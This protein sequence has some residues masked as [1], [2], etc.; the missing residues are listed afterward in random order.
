MHNYRRQ[1][2]FEQSHALLIWV[3]KKVESR[4]AVTR[5][6]QFRPTDS[7]GGNS[8]PHLINWLRT[9]SAGHRIVVGR[10][11]IKIAGKSVLRQAAQMQMEQIN[12]TARGSHSGVGERDFICSRMIRRIL[13]FAP[14]SE[15]PT[16]CPPTESPAA[17]RAKQF[18]SAG[19]LNGK[20]PSDS[21]A[22][23]NTGQIR[24]VGSPPSGS[25]RYFPC[26]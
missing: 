15:Y 20:S 8:L 5:R 2:G 10:G 1:N 24:T 17:P 25:L 4:S 12:M 7:P 22:R 13:P 9:K 6:S 21:P 23:F 16:C 26:F 19:V 14:A 18:S 3:Q 11:K